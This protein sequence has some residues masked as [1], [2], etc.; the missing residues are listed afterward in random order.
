ME[1][2]AKAKAEYDKESMQ[3]DS[4]MITFLDT[5]EYAGMIGAFEGAGYESTGL[6]R[7]SLNCIMFSKVP[8]FCPCLPERND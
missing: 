2:I 8:Y 4:A 3:H 6:Y 1:V 5:S 7:P